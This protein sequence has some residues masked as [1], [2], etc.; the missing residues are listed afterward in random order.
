MKQT[1]L[2]LFQA[3]GGVTSWPDVSQQ[4]YL[5]LLHEWFPSYV[6][7]SFSLNLSFNLSFLSWSC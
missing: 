4:L 2:T 5:S 6:V 1:V 7:C 3:P